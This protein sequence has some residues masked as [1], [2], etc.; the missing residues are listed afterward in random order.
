MRGWLITLVL[1]VVAVA[2]AGWYL[3]IR[4]DTATAQ[5]ETAVVQRADVNR[6]ASGSGV[7]RPT[8]T[9]PVRVYRRG[10][11][12]RVTAEEGAGIA[13]GD[14]LFRID[15]KPTFA[16]ASTVPFYRA[17]AADDEGSDV[18]ALQTLIHDL[19]YYKGKVDGV[20]NADSQEAV[21]DF[22][23]D[24][25]QTRTEKVGPETFQ[26]VGAIPSGG[27]VDSPGAP[28]VARFDLKIG[29]VVQPGREAL[30]AVPRNGLEVVV[31]VNELD[32]ALV[33]A[34]QKVMLTLDAL[35][36]ES[37]VGV[38]KT[39]SPGM[40]TSDP[41]AAGSGAVGANNGGRGV[42]TF[43]VTV[44]FDAATPRI[45]SGMS[46]EAE[47]VLA[48]V[49]QALTVPSAAVQMRGGKEVVLVAASGSETSSRP[50]PV[51]VTIGLRSDSTVEVL[52]GLSEGQTIIVG[53]DPDS[54]DLPEQGILGVQTRPN[55][56]PIGTGTTAY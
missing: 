19:G 2:A 52:Q 10:T 30:I 17:L 54:L 6:T 16:L 33:R 27:T 26:S 56:L 32:I 43:P 4:D 38:V 34:G 41:P 42:V 5:Y 23:E 8:K 25:G 14:E 47:I 31:D 1:I 20:Y 3:L 37:F 53:V 9:M 40:L 29:Q 13:A 35:P 49:A 7:V 48:S 12:T 21:R 45:L 50:T 24:R 28:T 55:S 44:S 18:K 51:P 22:L 39:V 36:G 15:N 46:V 11:V